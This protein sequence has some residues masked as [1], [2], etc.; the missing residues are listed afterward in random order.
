MASYSAYWNVDYRIEFRDLTWEEYN[1]ICFGVDPNNI[2]PQVVI[3]IYN[4]CILR[5]PDARLVTAGIGFFVAKHQIVNNP[6]SGRYENVAAALN[7]A[8][9]LV[10]GNYLLAAQA[11]IANTFTL[12]FEEIKGWSAEKFFLRMAQAELIKG[13]RLNP[14]PPESKQPENPVSPPPKGRRRR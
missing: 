10:S 7:S 1:R 11:V 14:S 8:R 12:P 13:D 6:F 2:P 4:T 9:E 3:D 5:G